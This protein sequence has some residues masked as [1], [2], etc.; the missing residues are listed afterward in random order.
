MAKRQ[1]IHQARFELRC[2]VEELATWRCAS[3]KHGVSLAR[4][5]RSCLNRGPVLAKHPQ[6]D[7]A[8][9][10]Q[11]A[12]IGN[13]VNQIAFWCNAHKSKQEVRLVEE[14]IQAIRDELAALL[15][16]EAGNAN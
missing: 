5:I 6:A 1:N 2:S 12:A 11:I 8:L 3:A 10:R 15:T 16:R 14:G 9:L 13:N 7:P 4:Y